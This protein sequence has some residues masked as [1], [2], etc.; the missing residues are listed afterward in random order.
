MDA[1]HH[2]VIVGGGFAGLHA[3]LE[4]GRAGCRVTLLDKRNFHLFQP[5]LYQVAT[6]AIPPGDIAIPHRVVLR[7]RRNVTCLTSAVFE[8]DPHARRIRHEHG[9][10][11]YDTLIVA[12]GVKHHYF[13]RDSWSAFAPGLKTVEHALE[14]RRKLF[15]AFERAEATED[16]AERARLLRFVIVG[17]GPTGVELAGAL[18]ELAHKTMVRDFRRIDP[19]SAQIL[20]VE[21]ADEVL[22]VYAPRLRAAARRHLEE[23]GVSVRTGTKVEEIGPNFVRMRR[24]NAEAETV[25]TATVL[26]A[27][28]VK[29][30]YFG[31]ILAERT[32]VLLDRGGRVK[33]EPDCSLP[34]HPEIFVI[35]DL[36]RLVDARGREVPGLAPAAIQQGRYVAAVIRARLRGKPAPPAFR[37]RDLGSMAVIGMNK[38]V[39][40]LRV[41]QVTGIFAWFIWAFVHIM[42]LIDA[43]QRVR[44]FVQWAWK[45]FTRKE[46]DR[47]ITGAPPKTRALRLD[48]QRR[49][50]ADS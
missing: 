47:L 48:S 25:E 45:Y 32:G 27:A 23:L 36:A 44:V 21:G 50:T 43:E 2:V 38:A 17:A 10:L 37:Y 39:G 15:Q 5:L 9:T 29:A 41:M 30:S 49:A 18:G 8:L 40:D 16:A 14:I 28:G 26:W 13:G 19:R 34:G 42:S 7:R 33:V 3:A 35:G 24:G 1:Q 11:D 12:T 20:L 31:E 6:G 4:L 22:P 46:G